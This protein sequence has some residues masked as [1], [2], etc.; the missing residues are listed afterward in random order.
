MATPGNHDEAGAMAAQ[1]AATATD[2]PLVFEAGGWRIVV[3]NS[4]VPGEVPGRLG[5]EV[6]AA[7]DGALAQ[8]EWPTLVALHHQPLP[9]G[10]PWIDKYP[11]LEPEGFW[12]VIHAHPAVRVVVWGHIHHAVEFDVNGVRAL[13]GPSSASNSLP[14]HE[15]F[16][17]DES[18]PACRWLKLGLDGSFE[19]GVLGAGSG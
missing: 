15:R 13:G 1:F 8:S 14:G 12:S 16:T 9:V 5:A 3:L 10:S 19:T 2:A 17:F 11:L 6:L 7:L 4:A 18:G